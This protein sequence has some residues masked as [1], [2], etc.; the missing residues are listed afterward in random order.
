MV[1]AANTFL[2]ITLCCFQLATHLIEAPL[3]PMHMVVRDKVSIAGWKRS[4][5][6][7]WEA[8]LIQPL[9]VTN[10]F[11][12]MWPNYCASASLHS[13]KALDT[14]NLSVLA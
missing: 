10:H 1:V 9:N 14:S 12:Y 5:N 2:Y 11:D 4:Q 3:C 13:R 7:I 8:Q 6:K